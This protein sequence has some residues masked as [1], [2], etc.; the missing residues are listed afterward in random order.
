MKARQPR[1][2]LAAGGSRQTS[3]NMKKQV[4]DDPNTKAA[5][6]LADKGKADGQKR[7]EAASNVSDE[8]SFQAT[9]AR[10]RK[11]VAAHELQT[12]SSMMTSNFGYSL[13]PVME[14]EGVFSYWDKHQLWPQLQAVLNQ[15]FAQK[16][17]FMV[18]PPEFAVD[19]KFNGF[20]AGFTMVNG[21]WKFA[22]F[23]H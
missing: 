5:S 13:S 11:A 20:R 10:L 21:T 3:A 16:N 23:V 15:S 22:Y 2:E 14:G 19:P 18:A 7:S 12:I 1:S 9:L 4:L 6:G 17:D 8:G